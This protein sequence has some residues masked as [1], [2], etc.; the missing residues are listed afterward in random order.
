MNHRY[1]VFG[2]EAHYGQ[3][4]AEACVYLDGSIELVQNQGMDEIS[5]SAEQFEELLKLRENYISSYYPEG[6]NNA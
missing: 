2:L 4:K 1:V 6:V 5:L 3:I